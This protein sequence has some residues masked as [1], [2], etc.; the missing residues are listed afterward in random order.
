MQRGEDATCNRRQIRVPVRP[1]GKNSPLFRR[2]MPES[3]LPEHDAEKY[4]P[5]SAEEGPKRQYSLEKKPFLA[6][7][8]RLGEVCLLGQSGRCVKRDGVRK[9]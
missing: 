8:R 7:W 4:H 5:P 6:A 3:Q 2:E 9:L 1:A